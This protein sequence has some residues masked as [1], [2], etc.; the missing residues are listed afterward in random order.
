MENN[1]ANFHAI[2]IHIILVLY[3]IIYIYDQETRQIISQSNVFLNIDTSVID[4][5][6]VA[7]NLF[8]GKL[9]HVY[10]MHCIV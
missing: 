10:S 5:I 2:Q 4:E 8:V 3:F 7:F 1:F 9:T 6:G